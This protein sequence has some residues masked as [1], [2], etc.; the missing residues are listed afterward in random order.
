MTLMIYANIPNNLTVTNKD[1][2]KL[3]RSIYNEVSNYATLFS[4]SIEKI[5]K[6]TTNQK[7]AFLNVAAVGI[8]YQATK[9]GPLIPG[10]LVMRSAML[11]SSCAIFGCSLAYKAEEADRERESVQAMINQLMI[12]GS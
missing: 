6:T 3:M 10:D 2:P 9:G 7:L 5:K 8:L 11:V 4:S 12:T 1:K